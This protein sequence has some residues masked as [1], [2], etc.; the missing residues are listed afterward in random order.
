M[1]EA[2]TQLSGEEM[3]VPLL[4]ARLFDN[5]FSIASIVLST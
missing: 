3:C 4:A 2:G 1:E 5:F